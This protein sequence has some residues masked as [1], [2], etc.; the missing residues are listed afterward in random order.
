M[1]VPKRQLSYV[2]VI[3]RQNRADDEMALKMLASGMKLWIDWDE[4]FLTRDEMKFFVR[5]RV[6]DKHKPSGQR[7]VPVLNLHT[8]AGCIL[9]RYDSD[10]AV[11]SKDE[12]VD[13]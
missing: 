4:L 5:D 2:E 3:H 12:V 10:S 7:L 1:K 13:T 11:P 8:S 9:L 6:V